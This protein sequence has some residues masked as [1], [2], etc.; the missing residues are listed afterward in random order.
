MPPKRGR[1]NGTLPGRT[2]KQQKVL[3][4]I[5]QKFITT[6]KSKLGDFQ[7]FLINELRSKGQ[8]NLAM[9]YKLMGAPET[10]KGIKRARAESRPRLTADQIIERQI[11]SMDKHS[12]KYDKKGRIF[13]LQSGDIL[14]FALMMYLD[15]YH[16]N[17]VN[18]DFP[19]FLKSGIH[20][21]FLKIK[22]G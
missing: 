15:M 1:E 5:D 19:G 17:T 8:E 6:T 16:D 12:I 7:Q 22:V 9:L 14:D 2:V 20:T 4:I 11:A 10:Y 3:N 21:T 18:T 13:D